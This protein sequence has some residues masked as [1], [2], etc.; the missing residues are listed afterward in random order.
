MECFNPI[1]I[2]NIQFLQAS[3]S[4][5]RSYA[6]GGLYLGKNQLL[7]DMIYNNVSSYMYVPCRKCPACIRRRASE[8]SGRLARE[9]Q[10]N[11]ES[12]KK[13]AFVTLTYD[14]THIKHAKKTWRKDISFFFD[15]LRSKYRRNIRHFCISE[16]GDNTGRFHIHTL[17]FD[18]PNDFAPSSHIWRDAHGFLHG[19]S[20][21]LAERWSL[22][23]IDTTIIQTVGAGVY[24]A[25][26]LN[27]NKP[28]KDGQYYVSPIIASN[29][30]GYKDV[31]QREI[32]NISSS[33]A[34]NM[35]PYYEVGGKRYQYPLALINKYLS[36]EDRL[37]LSALSA[38]RNESRGG[39]FKVGTNYFRNYSEFR[40]YMKS[41]TNPIIH[42]KLKNE[43]PNYGIKENTDF[44]DLSLYLP[45]GTEVVIVCYPQMVAESII[46]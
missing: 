1:R 11:L 40:E 13:C 22:G 43:N 44:L 10:F 21:I 16:L 27:K 33:L 19:S 4:V 31:T 30:I 46:Y 6:S 35:L 25:G 37:K 2:P 12:G 41:Y 36:L 7:A 17:L 29:G 9:I 23:L 45:K 34:C 39:Q 38:G 42:Y 5:I 18:V 3:T 8:W 14:E 24:V 15:K 20:P 26:Y 28:H 32:S